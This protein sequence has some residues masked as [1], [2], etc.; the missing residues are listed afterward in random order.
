MPRAL[1]HQDE[2]AQ[3]G[4]SGVV[5]SLPGP[6]LHRGRGSEHPA[7]GI[8][9]CSPAL[10]SSR[11]AD[12]ACPLLY[13]CW[14]LSRSRQSG[15]REGKQRI[16]APVKAAESCYAREP[17]HQ[18]LA[19]V[20]PHFWW[21]SM[22]TDVKVNSSLLCFPPLPPTSPPSSLSLCHLFKVHYL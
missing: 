19:L 9:L 14:A 15:S 22:S 17:Q 6:L 20:F 1:R 10:Y 18:R 5:P 21:K 8:P 2:K 4:V 11:S 3:A 7:G 13:H 16:A 12:P